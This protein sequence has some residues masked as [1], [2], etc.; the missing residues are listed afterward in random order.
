MNPLDWDLIDGPALALFAAIGGIA[1]LWLAAGRRR[2]VLHALVP[3]VVAGALGGIAAWFV[4]E[5]LLNLWGA[6]QPAWFYVL[7]GIGI[8]ALLLAIPKFLAAPRW[9]QRSLT[10]VAP[11]LVL[12]AV[13]GGINAYFGYFPTL[14]SVTGASNIPELNAVKTPLDAAPVTTLAAWTPPADMP[15]TGT[16]YQTTIPGT[17]SGVNAAPAY[18]YLPPAYLAS[19][20]ANVP[21]LVLIHGDPGGPKDW[22][23]GGQLPAV[24][25][26]YAAA[27][28]GLAPVVVLPDASAST[29]PTPSLCLDSN[30]GR[31][32]TYLST[33]VPTWVRETLGV[34]TH[35]ATDWAIGG[36]SYGGTCSLTL[37]TGHPDI[38]PTFLDISGED[39]PTIEAGQ[40]AL[41]RDYFSGD[42][43]AFAA[44]NPLDVIAA[45]PLPD[46]AGII[47]VGA[48][49]SFYRPQGEE[50]AAAMKKA[51]IN[52]QLQTI[53][54]G[55]TWAAWKAGLQNNVDWLMQRYGVVP[56]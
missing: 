32:G 16:V 27:H 13:A 11:V 19:T 15:S 23:T 4:S 5:K 25:D 20:P 36:F 3:S 49:D 51:G 14:G 50:V 26:A 7:G 48:D 6:P 52:V 38:Y 39:K 35:A 18:V 33:D 8:A 40:D 56:G 47:T 21:V 30:Y 34:G 12:A 37:A 41:I 53:P 9:W 17:V 54:G 2:Y 24:M 44:Q 29:G 55:H 46:I 10:V 22:I 43:A 31:A 45:K 42:A 1:L 28:K